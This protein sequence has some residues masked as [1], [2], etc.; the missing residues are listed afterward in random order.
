MSYASKAR[1]LKSR[2][3]TTCVNFIVEFYCDNL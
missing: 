3:G 2:V 1:E